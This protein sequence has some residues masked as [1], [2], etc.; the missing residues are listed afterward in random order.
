MHMVATCVGLGYLIIVSIVK[1]EIF[2]VWSWV[3]EEAHQKKAMFSF[4]LSI[5]WLSDNG[6]T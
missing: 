2:E 4:L 1:S 3:G 6:E 5:F